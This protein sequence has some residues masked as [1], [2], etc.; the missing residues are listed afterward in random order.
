MRKL[1]DSRRKRVA[2]A[3]LLSLFLTQI[4]AFAQQDSLAYVFQDAIEN[5]VAANDDNDFDYDTEFE[6]LQD[7]VLHPI[8]INTALRG[9]FEKITVLKPYQIDAILEHRLHHGKYL[10]L[11]E[12]QSVL[13]IRLIRQILPFITV[14]TEL[15]DYQ[16][17]IKEWFKQGKNE[18]FFRLERRLEKAKGFAGAYAGDAFK[19]YSRFR[20]SFGTRL[21]YGL[22]LEKDA[23]ERLGTM[24]DFYSFHFKI[25]N[26][27]RW[28]KTVC[29]G[30][31]SVS[32][33]QGLI[34]ENG[35]NIGKSALVLSIEKS[36]QPI[37][38]YTSSNEANFL[39]G[40]AVQMQWGRHTEGVVFVSYRQRDGNVIQP[41]ITDN[42]DS[43]AVVS[44]LQ[45]IG[46]HRTANEIADKNGV[47]LWTAGGRILTT[48]KHGYKALNWV[49][50]HFDKR[51]EP[52]NEP[53]NVFSFRGKTLFNISTD[54]KYT[55]QNAH[56]FG[57]SAVSDNGG[58]ATLNGLLLGLDKRLSLAFLNRLFSERYQA[59]NSQPFAESSKA[60]NEKG[61]YA[62]LDFKIHNR[63][64]VSSYVDI[65]RHN[66]WRFRVDAP[67]RGFDY[68]AKLS[69]KHK[70]T[71]GY[72]QFRTKTREEN[73]S[74]PDSLK[75]NITIPK[76]KS[77]IRVHWQY[78][79][80]K[81]LIFRNRLETSFYK[82]HDNSN[83]FMLLQDIIF[84]CPLPRQ[85][86]TDYPLSITA[87]L[88]IFDTDN[89]Q[90][91]IYTYEND[92]LYSFN[93]TPYY[94]RGTRFYANLSYKFSKKGLF[95]IR[96]AR[97]RLTNR[98]TIGSGN[99]EIN[100]PHRTDIKTQLYF[101]F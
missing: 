67:S 72:V 31:Y 61:L 50:N 77:Q 29:I 35:F 97:T 6:H 48:R 62:G 14:E 19:A 37:K 42:T 57:E 51:I 12:L 93:V 101:K 54:Y 64:I 56:F 49:L 16:L 86:Y 47:G 63:L 11:W 88:A 96:F 84:K 4:T 27:V 75:I 44:A 65:W 94:Y 52:R 43:V 73:V 10:T 69:F 60:N 8:N 26:P 55:Y 58:W 74:R 91:A 33:G 98:N 92:L 78:S 53:Y 21:S 22:T 68:F 23:G 1:P 5:A 81:Q 90:S 36:N 17:P 32:L 82:A 13:D 20:Y 95:E 45:L 15:D 34:H 85:T 9:D 41:P 24:P 39:R 100:A 80:S 38:S 70:H 2:W 99:D 40:A 76:T 28:L 83:G 30:D 87:R 89:Y 71:E 3:C 79:L 25:K 46:L 18:A 59:I 7:L 66:W